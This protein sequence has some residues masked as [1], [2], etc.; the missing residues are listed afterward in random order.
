MVFKEIGTGL[1]LVWMV[2]KEIGTGLKHVWMAFKEIGTGLK[3]VWMAFKETGTGQ[4]LVWMVFKEVGIKKHQKMMLFCIKRGQI[5][6]FAF[7]HPVFGIPPFR[8]IWSDNTPLYIGVVKSGKWVFKARADDE[9]NA[10]SRCTPEKFG[11]GG[12]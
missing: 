2:F 1:K 10:P 6:N 3:H 4:K 7:A 11:T 8:G 12:I 5:V 9:I